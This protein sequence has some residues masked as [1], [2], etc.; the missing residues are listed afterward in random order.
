MYT[1]STV[2]LHA[3]HNWRIHTVQHNFT[4]TTKI[5]RDFAHTQKHTFCN[6]IS[7][8][9]KNKEKHEFRAKKIT[10]QPYNHFL[11]GSKFGSLQPKKSAPSSTTR[12]PRIAHYHI[13]R[14]TSL[15]HSYGY[16]RV[17]T[18]APLPPH[19]ASQPCL[20]VMYVPPLSSHTMTHNP[21]WPLHITQHI[22]PL[23]PSYP[24]SP[25]SPSWRS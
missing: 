9:H 14:H 24:T 5:H 19:P 17:R 15:N 4:T 10:V 21:A 20:T 2:S 11:A 1:I 3:A 23:L 6:T 18:D 7:H 13:P 8:T 16:Q 22:P 25:Y 12:H